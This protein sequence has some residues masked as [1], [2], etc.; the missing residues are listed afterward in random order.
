MLIVALIYPRRDNAWQ[1]ATVQRWG[2]QL[3]DV[4]NVELKILGGLPP[5]KKLIVSNHISWLDNFV[6][7]ALCPAHF[8]AKSEIRD[9]PVMGWLVAHTGAL[10]IERARRHHTLKINQDMMAAL[11][12][13]DSVALF[14]EG[15]TG[16][17]DHVRPFHSALLQACI[18]SNAPLIPLGLRYLSVD[19]GQTHSADYVGEMNFITSLK[20]VLREEKMVAEL[21][22]GEAVHG[23]GK[24]RRDLAYEAEQAVASL[25]GLAAPHRILKTL[26][27]LPIETH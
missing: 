12:S 17:G 7:Q 2:Q 15:T 13:G 21:R 3:L 8:V 25:L 16:T 4:L 20:N 5:G 6:V 26:P 9:W 22:I 24:T 27:D 19:G 18:G 14:P 10:F 11:D 23:A 1:R